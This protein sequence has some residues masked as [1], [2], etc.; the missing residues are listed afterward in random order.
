[1]RG[2]ASRLD[3]AGTGSRPCGHQPSPLSAA[4]PGEDFSRWPAP[5]CIP[6]TVLSSCV[7]ALRRP[8]AGLVGRVAGDR[9]VTHQGHRE[10]V[11]MGAQVPDFLSG[12]KGLTR[13]DDG[14][15]AHQTL[16][17]TPLTGAGGSV[18]RVST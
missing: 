5:R 12:T 15:K 9:P 13:K 7:A 10:Q 4:E 8:E 16:N 6:A 14:F 2:R 18:V 11:Q 17:R 3:V 1:M